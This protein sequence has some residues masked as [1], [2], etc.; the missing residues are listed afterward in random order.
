MALTGWSGALSI[1]AT[2]ACWRV[3]VFWWNSDCPCNHHQHQ[4]CAT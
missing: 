2:G 3:S 1:G 4:Q